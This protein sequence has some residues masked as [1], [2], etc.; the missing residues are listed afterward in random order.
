MHEQAFIRHKAY[1]KMNGFTFVM[2]SYGKMLT[3]IKVKDPLFD[4]TLNI[5]LSNEIKASIGSAIH[6]ISPA[7][8]SED[9]KFS[10]EYKLS[11][12]GFVDENGNLKGLSIENLNGKNVVLDDANTAIL[13][14]FFFIYLNN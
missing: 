2:K 11:R 14:M 3:G 8:Y 5:I 6:P 10:Q 9:F 1:F 13:S 7:H 4:K 12:Q